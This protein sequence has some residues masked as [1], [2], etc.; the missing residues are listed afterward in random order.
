MN[1]YELKVTVTEIDSLIGRRRFKEA[2]EVADAVD[3]RKVRNVRTLCRVSDVYKINKRY[4]DSKKI[5]ELAYVK[6]PYARQI[7]FSLCE[8]ELKLGNYVRALQLYNEYINVAPRDADRFV[9]QYK[10][11]KAQ[12]VSVNERIAVLEELARHDMRDRWAFELARLYLEAGERTLCASQCDEIIAFFGEGRYVLKA[13]ELKASFT[14]LTVKQKSLYRRMTGQEE[15]EEYIPASQN[16]TYTE[17]REA[18]TADADTESRADPAGTEP[19][20]AE[21]GAQAE[22]GDDAVKSTG[23]DE[24]AAGAET[25]PSAQPPEGAGDGTDARD[26]AKEAGDESSEL[27]PDLNRVPSADEIPWEYEDYEIQAK[28]LRKKPARKRSG[29]ERETGV[30][31][32]TAARKA[33]EVP[34]AAPDHS[35]FEDHTFEISPAEDAMFSQENMQKMLAKGIRDLENYD[36]YLRQ[37]TDGQYAMVIQEE[38][39]PDKQITGQ[40]NL[41]E[42]MSEW[43]KVKRDFYES[44]GLEDDEPAEKPAQ[45]TFDKNKKQDTGSM[46]TKS[47]DRREVQKALQIKDDD[48]DSAGFDTSLFV[49]EG[50][51][52]FPGE[53]VVEKMTI[54]NPEQAGRG[55]SQMYLHSEDSIRQLTDALGRI[56]LEGGTGNVVITGDEGAGTLSLARELVR[57]YRQI[58]PNFVGQIAKSEGRY[59]T[60]ENMLRVIP[61]MPFGALIIERASMMSEEGVAALCE[62]LKAPER[63]ILI[64]MIDRKGVMD[65]ILHDHPRMRDM[66]PA[67]VD[68]AALSVDTLLGYAREYAGKQQ[69]EIDEYGISALQS[70]ILSSQTVNH[71]VTLED[72]RDIVD[73]AIYYAS[74]KSL[75]SLVDSFSRRK[76][77][78]NS[79]IILRD[80]DF[81]HY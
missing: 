51:G 77:G 70:R 31:H 40:L 18:D 17:D 28:E 49:T 61:R 29:T 1:K 13:L 9:L 53:F 23:P 5:L 73:E 66:F 56:F 67:R 27:I 19:A 11:Y 22:A 50:G 24:D 42:I 79:R 78:A 44:N 39:K 69:C 46:Y 48:K 45:R 4:D 62:L 65:A 21:N 75:S 16:S 57:R 34:K 76:S 25:D 15:E 68:I 72:I 71:S 8:L 74:R 63:S 14:E 26:A 6:N 7:I 36:T 12:N 43:E 52:E 32:T 3:W 38:T 80:K 10:L 59:I 55:S 47:W 58:N 2:A 64:I 20:G 35:V 37:E 54:N 33:A 41:E 60:R 30:Q 81:L